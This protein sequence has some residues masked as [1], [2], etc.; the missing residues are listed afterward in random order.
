[1]FRGLIELN[2]RSCELRFSILKEAETQIGKEGVQIV[3]SEFFIY[4]D[5][6]EKSNFLDENVMKLKIKNASS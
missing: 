1:M 2:S 3:K 5:N 6:T 4:V